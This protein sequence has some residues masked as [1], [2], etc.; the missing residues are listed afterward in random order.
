MI[1]HL[2]LPWYELWLLNLKESLGDNA[3]LPFWLLVIVWLVGLMFWIARPHWRPWLTLIGTLIL[4]LFPAAVFC[5]F[6]AKVTW[7]ARHLAMVG[8]LDDPSQAGATIWFAS[9]EA[10]MQLLGFLFL[11]LFSAV[12]YGRHLLTN[13]AAAA[14]DIESTPSQQDDS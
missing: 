2:T 5:A 10:R 14:P 7:V 13:R 1:G 12:L 8:V 4:L 6:I 9:S 11:T 3:N